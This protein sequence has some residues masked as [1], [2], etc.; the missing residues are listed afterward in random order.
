MTPV[1]TVTIQPVEDP[2]TPTP[3]HYDEVAAQLLTALDAFT[4]AVP[5]LEEA[6]IFEAK[7]VRRNLNVPEVFCY[8]AINAAEQIPELED[9]RK[10]YA[11]KTRNRLQYIAAFDPLAVKLGAVLRRVLHGLRANKSAAGGDSLEIYRVLRAKLKNSKNPGLLAHA[12]ALKIALAK[13]SLTKAELEERK[14]KKFNDA[15]EQEV[16]RR[17]QA[18]LAAKEKEVKAA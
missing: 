4:G 6:A 18:R 10:Q 17:L 1:I 2:L 12:E 14:T 9:V 11:E 13:K 16:E 5:K 3:S 7:Q 15:V 8:S